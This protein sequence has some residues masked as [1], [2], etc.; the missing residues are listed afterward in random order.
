MTQA[1]EILWKHLRNKKLNGMKF[2]R[3]H[4]LDMFIADFY[5]HEKK[6]IIELDGGIHET[7]EQQEYD[8]GRT[9]LL[10]DKDLRFCD[11]EMKR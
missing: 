5:C 10:Q 8:E 2:R 9:F 11:L 7:P 1:E 6:L 3:Q 4:P